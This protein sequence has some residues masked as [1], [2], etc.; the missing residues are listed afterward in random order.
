MILTLNVTRI[1]NQTS[2]EGQKNFQG[3][4]KSTG[5]NKSPLKLE[6]QGAIVDPPL[7]MKTKPQFC[8]LDIII[9]SP[10]LSGL[11]LATLVYFWNIANVKLWMMY[12]LLNVVLLLF[13]LP[14]VLEQM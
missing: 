10:L 7:L 2:R 14:L 9:L 4:A 12:V 3:G 8:H 6:I 13:W 5:T 1:T 11:V